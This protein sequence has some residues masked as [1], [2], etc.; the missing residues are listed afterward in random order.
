MAA[1]NVSFYRDIRPIF[2][3]RCQG[4]HQPAKSLGGLV[5]TNYAN[6]K[7]GGES[8]AAG[9]VP[10]KPDESGIAPLSQILAASATRQRRCRRARR[11]SRTRSR[12]DPPL[13]CRRSVADD[14]PDAAETAPSIA[15]IRRSMR[16]RLC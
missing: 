5:M 3:D 10:G 4:C 1:P 16:R 15:I 8:G 12:P 14:T 7:K 9:F 13:D 11:S 6:I 2:Q